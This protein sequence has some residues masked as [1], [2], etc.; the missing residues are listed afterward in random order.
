M[1]TSLAKGDDLNLSYELSFEEP[2][3]HY[4]EVSMTVSGLDREYVDLK[5]AV[6]APG[7]YLIREFSKNVEAFKAESSG[8][9]L[10]SGKISKNTWRVFTG[11]AAEITVNYRV[12]AFEMS[13]R[14]SFIDSDHAY[15]NGTSIFMYVDGA[16]ELPATIKINP[17]REWKQI[18]TGLEAD[19]ADPFLLSSPNYDILADSPIEIGNQDIIEFEA[20]GLPHE[21]A[22]YGGGDYDREKVIADFTKIIEEQTAIFGDHPCERYVF[23]VHFL[24]SG[25]GGLEHLNSTTLQ[26]PRQAVESAQGWASFL[27][28]VAHEYFHLWNV[29]RLRP[30]ALGPFNYEAENYTHMLWVSEGFTAYYDDWTVRRTGFYS[31]EE[32]LE[33]IAGVIGTVENT[34]GNRVQPVTEASFDAWI[35]YYRPNENS[36]NTT[37]SYYSKGAILGMLIDMSIRENSKGK[38][39][40]DDLMRY[41]YDRYYKELDRGFEDAEFKEAVEKFAGDMDDF[42]ENYVWGT[43]EIPYNEFF[44]AVGLKLVES[45]PRT[46]EAYLGASFEQTGNGLVVSRVVRGTA[47][48]TSGINVNDLLL[49]VNGKAVADVESLL[50]GRK[51]GDELSL[52]LLRNG[53]VR[54]I[55]VV[56]GGNENSSF[57]F[58]KIS[59]PGAQQQENYKA[60]MGL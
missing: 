2:Y 28:L 42:F 17:Y 30:A 23:I 39:S 53:M 7:S 47:A 51:P 40:L 60:W 49:S 52:K 6:W 31:P 55:G 1:T 8:K 12:Y 41:M 59:N 33:K 26:F 29:K 27:G 25:G 14:T 3:T 11:G 43:E 56:L 15:L 18:S 45:Q 37:I 19:A 10:N 9:E 44:D 32:Y 50:E 16:Q 35:K 20:A 57:R 46:G 22:I 48:Y 21:V 54:T 24:A 38:H 58:E 36:Y 13:V 34:P 5:M 4:A